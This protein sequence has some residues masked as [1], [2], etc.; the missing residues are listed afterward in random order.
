MG[1]ALVK[2]SCSLQN[3]LKFI[4][5][6]NASVHSVSISI[7]FRVGSIYET[8]KNYGIS[9]LTEHMF[10][11]RLHHLNNAELYYQ[12]ESIGT[13]L[14][15]RTFRDCV[16]FE[17]VVVP[18]KIRKIVDL[19]L[20]IFADFL[21]TQEELDAERAVIK[22]QM[23]FSFQGNSDYG[24]ELY[25]N[26]E[27]YTVPIMGEWYTVQSISLEELNRW[28]RHY[29]QCSNAAVVLT[30]NFSFEDQN[31]IKQRLSAIKCLSDK[32]VNRKWVRPKNLFCRDERD[33]RVLPSNGLISDVW[34]MF[35]VDLCTCDLS[36]AQML[37]TILGGWNGSRLPYLLIDTHALTDVV[38]SFT[39]QYVGFARISI[40]YSV[41]GEDLLKSLQYV[42]DT[43]QEVKKAI[44]QSDIVKILPFFTDNRIKDQDDPQ[45]Q[46]FTYGIDEWILNQC[47]DPSKSMNLTSSEVIEMLEQAAKTIFCPQNLSIFIRNNRNEVKQSA[48]KKFCAHFRERL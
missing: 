25:F 3:G 11:R 15:G 16:C 9:H 41:L 5:D 27:K 26:H 4:T 39:Y 35:D 22:K 45:E 7:V 42:F 24:E 13:E 30:G 43:I 48:V 14:R 36:A 29:F 37:S 10:F 44:S 31:Y 47:Y 6:S 19:L 21:W 17:A 12:T 18:Q 40:E 32:P 46:S 38:S 33:T 20:H 2:E 23:D 1:G 34:I 8:S 28:K